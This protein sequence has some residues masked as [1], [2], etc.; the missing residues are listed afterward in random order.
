MMLPTVASALLLCCVTVLVDET[1]KRLYTLRI[2]LVR[3][4]SLCEHV[5]VDKEQQLRHVRLKC[6]RRAA[7]PT[8]LLVAAA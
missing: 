4:T 5:R 1:V 3:L 8:L 2:G 6:W 7:P